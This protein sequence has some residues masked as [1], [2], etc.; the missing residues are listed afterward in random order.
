VR[1]RDG[2]DDR[3]RADMRARGGHVADELSEGVRV[4]RFDVPGGLVEEETARFTVA[5]VRGLAAASVAFAEPNR[6]RRTLET[7]PNDTLYSLQWHYSLIRLPEAWDVTTGDSAVVVAVIDTGM[8]SHPDL[9][10]RWIDGYDFMSSDGLDGNGRDPDPTDPGRGPYQFAGSFHGSH[11]AGT[12]GART[13]NGTGV[14]GVAWNVRLMPVRVLSDFGG[15]DADIAEGI[16]YAAQLSNAAGVVPSVRA[17]VINMSIGGPGFSQTLAN[18]VAA[19]RAAGVVIVAAAGNAGTSVLQ[20]PASYTGVISVGAVDPL[21]QRTSYSSY[22]T[23]LDIMA[24][25]GESRNDVTGDGYGDGVLSTIYDDTTLPA[26]PTYAFYDGTSMATPHVAGVAALLLSLDPTLTPDD[27]EGILFG[28][29]EDLG[30]AGRDNLTGHGLLDAYSAVLAASQI[31]LPPPDEGPPALGLFPDTLVFGN[32]EVTKSAAVVNLGGGVLTVGAPDVSTSD[33]GGWL[34]ATLGTGSAEATA[35]SILV[36]VNRA[37]LP[38]GVYAGTVFVHSDGGEG[39]L[40]IALTVQLFPPPAPD[41]E[42]HVRA[43]RVDTG[44]VVQEQV[45]TPA[46][47]MN[48]TFPS[49]PTGAYYFVAGTDFDD[50]GV[51]GEMGDLYGIY[52]DEAHAVPVDVLEGVPVS[53]LDFPVA[54]RQG[55]GV[56]TTP[57]R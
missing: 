10:G 51:I 34:S 52:R 44:Q 40:Q 49:L 38:P 4:V 57:G 17:D 26:V 11:V 21:K 24:P 37:G 8:T 1:F 46:Q 16:R 15:T 50:D 43:V 12:V 23:M 39:A 2:D 36:T 55:F 47:S 53:G 13:N 31:Q 32:S 22:G 9:M 29:A 56:A 54:R 42:I 48:W 45:V 33:G 6:I 30:V 7:E 25:G 18:A 35:A 19:A 5:R 20:Y 41:A 3:A 27:V 28:T 14:A